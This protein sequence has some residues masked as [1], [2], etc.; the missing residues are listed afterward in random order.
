MRAVL[1]AAPFI[2]PAFGLL[3]LVQQA[4]G[5]LHLGYL[6]ASAPAVV[7]TAWLAP[8]VSYRRRDALIA[9][10]AWSW[11]ISQIAWRAAL[12][13]YRDWTPRSEEVTRSSW[14]SNPRYA[15]FWWISHDPSH[16][17]T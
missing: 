1:I 17:K 13:P 5:N 9:V 11:L 2:L 4:T 14:H 6:V 10:I 3:Y 15:G 8:R 16:T 7:M 12:F